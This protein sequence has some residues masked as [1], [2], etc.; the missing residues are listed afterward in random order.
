MEE[1]SPMVPLTK[2]EQKQFEIKDKEGKI[3]IVDFSCDESHIFFDVSFKGDLLN[4]TYFLSMDLC[5]LKKSCKTFNLLD[6]YLDTFKFINDLFKINK[7]SI[8]MEHNSLYIIM[9]VPILLKEEEIKFSLKKKEKT[10][11]DIIND[12]IQ[13]VK[14]LKDENI[15][16]KKRLTQL[17]EWKKE[18]ELKEKKEIEQKEKEKEKFNSKLM[19]TEEQINLIKNVFSNRG[20]DIKRLQLLFSSS[21]DGDSKD[22]VHNK[23]DG[24]ENILLIVETKKGRKFGGYSKIGFDSSNAHKNDDQAFLFSFDKLKIYNN[25]NKGGWAIYCNEDELPWFYSKYGKYNI[26]L[27]N[28]FLSKV[29]YTTKKG[30]CFNTTEDYELN[31]GEEEFIVKELEYFQIIFN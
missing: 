11:D 23:I 15:E 16:I 21:K 22:S 10:K 31:G 20:Q 13:I 26:H 3:F 4:E 1:I 2:K 27:K 9:M 28:N 5:E 8:R 7:V 12:L 14:K 6:N 19:N 18:K 17:E 25:I 30:D 29:G 24:K